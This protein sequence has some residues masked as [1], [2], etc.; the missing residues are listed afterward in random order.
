[1]SG[2][3]TRSRTKRW[4]IR[5]GLLV[6]LGLLVSLKCLVQF[7][8][9]ARWEKHELG[10]RRY[11][12]VKPPHGRA[13]TAFVFLFHAYDTSP[14]VQESFFRLAETAGEKGWWLVLPQGLEDADGKPFWNATDACCAFDEGVT[15]P[16]DVAFVSAVLAGLDTAAEKELPVAAA[17]VSNGAFFAQRLACEP[18]WAE[19]LSAVVAVAGSGPTDE[20]C[21]AQSPLSVMLVHGTDDDVVRIDGG[22]MGPRG[23]PYPSMKAL[24]ERWHRRNAGSAEPAAT[25]SRT[26][27]FDASVEGEESRWLEA[28][29]VGGAHVIDVR[30]EGGSHRLRPTSVA[31]AE[32]AS[33]LDEAIGRARPR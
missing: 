6:A 17:G 20:D 19:R 5:L 13:P 3:R 28:P 32:L 12:V 16:D 10:E 22:K 21:S 9:W 2:F 23:A 1:M 18:A 11:W 29:G 30:V 14:R 31:R 4:A 27:D 25:S 26:F 33:F 24:V 15:P 8:G 7:R